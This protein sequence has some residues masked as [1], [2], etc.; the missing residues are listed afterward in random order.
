[1][2]ASNK[3]RPANDDTLA[4]LGVDVRPV[5]E[6]LVHGAIGRTVR[7]TPNRRTVFV[8]GPVALFGKWREHGLPAGFW[9]V[10]TAAD[11][12]REWHWLHVL[13]LMGLRVPEPVCWIG[14]RSRSLLVTNRV[15]GRGMDAWMRVAEREGWLEQLFDYVLEHVAPAIR[16][17][18]AA[19]VAYRDLYWNHVFVSDPRA[20]DEPVFL[21]VERAFR[22]LWRWRRWVV[23]DL[24]GL[25][26][27]V[28]V[29]L[30]PSWPLRFLRQYTGGARL[31]PRW[32]AAIASKARRIRGHQ[33]KFG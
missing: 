23:K 29:E 19:G 27:S 26:A 31:D 28:S 24:A 21:D 12:A 11:A 9:R 33:P 14:N 25:L 30:P 13:P 15:P 4:L 16:R 2:S 18:H 1:M 10:G 32:L 17:L 20:G 7:C 22:P 6:Q 8:D 5:V 3:P